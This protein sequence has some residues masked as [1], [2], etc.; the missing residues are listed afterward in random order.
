MAPKGMMTRSFGVEYQEETLRSG[1][2]TECR[3]IPE[4]SQGTTLPVDTSGHCVS[5]IPRHRRELDMH[6]VIMLCANMFSALRL[7][8]R[9]SGQTMSA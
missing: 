5:M 3:G 2:V 1:D 4:S 7:L 9:T 8:D 6:P